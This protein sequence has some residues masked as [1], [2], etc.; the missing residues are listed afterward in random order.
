MSGQKAIFIDRDGTIIEDQH[1]PRDAEAVKLLPGATEGL[2][3][4]VKKGYKLYVIRNQSGVGRGIIS[5]SEF[6]GVHQRTCELLQEKGIEIVEFA[7]CLHHP[8]DKCD[9]R[10]PEIGLVPK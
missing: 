8:E 2:Q 1:Y 5:D 6:I 4:M 7:Y 9:C 10:K 3:M